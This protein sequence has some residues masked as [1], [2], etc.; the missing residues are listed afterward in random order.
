MSL[1]GLY[2]EWISSVSGEVTF[3]FTVLTTAANELM[4]DIHNSKKRMP[5]ILERENEDLWLDLSADANRIRTLTEPYPSGIL[6][7]WEVS[8]LVGNAKADRN[9]PE[10]IAPYTRIP[11]NTLF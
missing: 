5:L 10:V 6:N 2:S 8:P 11:D 4:A 1:A 3:S 9:R 7:A